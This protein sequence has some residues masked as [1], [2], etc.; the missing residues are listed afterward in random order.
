MYYYRC[1]W[2]GE[3]Q[4]KVRT[5]IL[6]LLFESSPPQ[7]LLFSSFLF[8]NDFVPF[9]LNCRFL[10]NCLCLSLNFRSTP[11]CNTRSSGPAS[12]TAF[13]WMRN[14]CLSSWRRRGMPHTWSASGTW[15]CT[16]TT[17][18]PHAVALTRTLVCIMWKKHFTE[19]I[20]HECYSVTAHVFLCVK[21]CT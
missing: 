8:F 1:W 15:A 2:K 9:L 6:K 4:D 5:F 14:F 10:L 7:R 17:A 3:Q 13:L 20:L 16:R 11:V 19:H 18:C 12:L 21:S